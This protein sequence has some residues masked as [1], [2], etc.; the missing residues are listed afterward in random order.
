MTG[1][2]SP[3]TPQ[4]SHAPS[5]RSRAHPPSPPCGD[6]K[7]ADRLRDDPR[8][9]RAMVR[10]VGG[11]GGDARA[12]ARSKLLDCRF[13]LDRRAASSSSLGCATVGPA[14]TGSP[15]SPAGNP[16]AGPR[17]N[18]S[19]GAVA[20][21]FGQRDPPEARRPPSHHVP[22]SGRT[23]GRHWWRDREPGPEPGP[24]QPRCRDLGDTSPPSE[25]GRR[26]L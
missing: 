26:G 20:N 13:G 12:P 11:P 18:P 1:Y 17:L 3:V 15:G 23:G 16:G 21:A 5:S 10:R 8:G 7:R 19:L 2:L 25:S 9:C 6:P 14:F 22:R 4:L 24:C